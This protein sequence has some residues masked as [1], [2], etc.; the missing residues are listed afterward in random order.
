M[1]A[2]HSIGH[3]GWWGNDHS[4]SGEPR[5]SQSHRVGITPVL[6]WEFE[7]LWAPWTKSSLLRPLPTPSHNLPPGWQSNQR[8]PAIFPA[9]WVPDIDLKQLPCA[10][11]S[12]P[13]TSLSSCPTAMLLAYVP[14]VV[15]TQPTASFILRTYWP[16]LPLL[17]LWLPHLSWPLPLLLQAFIQQTIISLLLCSECSAKKWR[18]NCKSGLQSFGLRGAQE[19]WTDKQTCGRGNDGKELENMVA[20][21]QSSMS[22][23]PWTKKYRNHKV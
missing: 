19:K 2:E 21:S 16:P 4:Y 8:E 11:P 12:P 22:S 13:W 7:R 15:L 3:L 10:F 5:C 23:T 20:E 1:L 9:H 18:Y 14:P 17:P 6:Q